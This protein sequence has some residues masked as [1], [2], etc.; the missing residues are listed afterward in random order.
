MDDQNVQLIHKH[1]HPDSSGI[2]ISTFYNSLFTFLDLANF[3]SSG[4]VVA[5]VIE[6][7]RS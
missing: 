5:V 3:N 6:F 4:D 2:H 7:H 1:S